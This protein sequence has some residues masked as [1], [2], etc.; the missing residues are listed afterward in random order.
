MRALLI[1]LLLCGRAMAD[2]A[3]V[4]TQ[5]P[6]R[7]FNCTH[8]LDGAV[9]YQKPAAAG[10]GDAMSLHLPVDKVVK[11]KVA[12]KPASARF[13]IDHAPPGATLT[14]ATFNWKVAGTPGQTFTFDLVATAGDQTTRWPITIVIANQELFTAWSAGYGSVW[15]DCSKFPASYTVKDLDGDGRDDVIYT[16]AGLVEDGHHY[17]K[18][19]VMLQRGA[20]LKFVEAFTCDSCDPD[21]YA[22]EDGTHV[23]AYIDEG[24]C[25]QRDLH[26]ESVDDNAVG[27]DHPV[28]QTCGGNMTMVPEV[29]FNKNAR[30]RVTSITLTPSEQQSD[31]KPKT[32]PWD[33]ATKTFH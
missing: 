31:E 1:V 23:F 11:F 6:E 22:T 9:A 33:K 20:K 8:Y 5:G 17:D 16:D 24:C 18:S 2:G 25:C 26:I 14:G 7:A 4:F 27:T 29:T 3:P 19:H 21:V 30:G 10:P 28:H 12:A 32:W 13:S 15:P